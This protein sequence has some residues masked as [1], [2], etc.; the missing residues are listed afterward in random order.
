MIFLK[1]ILWLCLDQWN[2][3]NRLIVFPHGLGGVSF[4][5]I[6]SSASSFFVLDKQ[7]ER[8]QEVIHKKI[9]GEGK[10]DCHQRINYGLGEKDGE[11]SLLQYF[12]VVGDGIVWWYR[13]IFEEVKLR[14]IWWISLWYR[15]GQNVKLNSKLNF[16]C[17][18]SP[19]YI[20]DVGQIK[21]SKTGAMQHLTYFTRYLK[22]KVFF[23]SQLLDGVQKDSWK[24]WMIALLWNSLNL[25]N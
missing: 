20:C 11:W 24:K 8:V 6:S 2:L 10:Q 12:C 5:P 22:Q 25:R 13:Y 14:T 16:R 21:V 23:A 15:S 7:L 18:H 1:C 4:C 19:S 3:Q 9:G 17:L